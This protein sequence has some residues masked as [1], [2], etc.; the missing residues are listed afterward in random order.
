MTSFEQVRLITGHPP[1]EVGFRDTQGIEFGSNW[2]DSLAEGLACCQTFVPVFTP[3]YFTRPYCGREWWAFRSRVERYAREHSGQAPRLILPVLWTAPHYLPGDLPEE[4]REI[5]FTHHDLGEYYSK[6]GLLQVMKQGRKCKN[7]YEKFVEEFAEKLRAAWRQWALTPGPRCQFRDTR[8]F[9]E[10]R[11][12]QVRTA[13]DG[14]EAASGGGVPAVTPTAPAIPGSEARA[15]QARVPEGITAAPLPDE[16][17]GP[18]YAHFLFVAAR[19]SELPA[20]VPHRDHSAYDDDGAFWKPYLPPRDET[21]FTMATYIARRLRF[22]PIELPIDS[23]ID[24][25]LDRA[26]A[27]ERVVVIVVDPWTLLLPRYAD[28]MRRCDRVDLYNCAI[29]IAWNQ[30]DPQTRQEM[31]ALTAEARRTF[32][33]KWSNRPANFYHDAATSREAFSDILATALHRAQ[34]NIIEAR[35]YVRAMAGDGPAGIPVISATLPR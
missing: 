14:G 16:T 34:N 30:Q 7:D 17:R 22:T 25:L 5:Q 2:P 10:L 12:S 33:S 13:T 1:A 29:L 31:E 21:V 28:L 6:E 11:K 23:E 4:I 35:G 18:R 8:N 24:E 27:E 19:R 32:P 20:G 9:F 26:R 15:Q 3:T